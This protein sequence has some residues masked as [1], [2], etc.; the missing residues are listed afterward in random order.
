MGYFNKSHVAPQS[1]SFSLS[2]LKYNNN[3]NGNNIYATVRA[4]GSSSEK[5]RKNDSLINLIGAAAWRAHRHEQ[6]PQRC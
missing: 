2:P 5:R 1:S 4:T 3:N 6:S